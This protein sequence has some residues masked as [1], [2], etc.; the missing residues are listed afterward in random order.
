M[1][2]LNRQRKSLVGNLRVGALGRAEDLFVELTEKGVDF[3]DTERL[4]ISKLLDAGSHLLD[5]IV[6]E[7]NAELLDTVLDGIPASESVSNR[8]IASHSTIFC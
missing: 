1:R 8:D 2:E 7:G 3:F 5:F 4:D 6:G